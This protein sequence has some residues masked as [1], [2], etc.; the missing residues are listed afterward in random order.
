VGD[1]NTDTDLTAVV[2]TDIN[3]QIDNPEPDVNDQQLN[4][5]PAQMMPV[6]THP[7]QKHNLVL[8][9]F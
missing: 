8:A 1:D 3:P 2:E 6:W 4:S 9:Q 7:H 5:K